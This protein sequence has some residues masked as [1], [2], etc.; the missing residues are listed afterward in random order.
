MSVPNLS[1]SVEPTE[2]GKAVYLPLAPPFDGGEGQ[3]KIV[4]C[5]TMTNNSG[6][7]LDV[8]KIVYSFPGTS[9]ADKSMTVLPLSIAA[10][11]TAQW[12]NG[13]GTNP[14]ESTFYD[15][16]YLDDA[17]PK[18]KVAVSC[19]GFSSP[20]TKT[21]DL[22]AFSSPNGSGGFLFPFSYADLREDEFMAASA[23]HWANGGGPGTQIF[24]HD[25]GCVGADNG[26]KETLDDKD[27]SKNSHWRIWGK[28]VRAV[29]DGVVLSFSDGMDTNTV[30]GEFPTPTPSP[31]GGNNIWVQHG[32]Y[33]V[34]YCHFQKNT[35][36]AKLKTGTPASPVKVK[37]GD[38]L[39]KAGNS[40]NTTNPHTHI[41]CQKTDSSGALRG[42]PW[43]NMFVSEMG[44]IDDPPGPDGPWARVSGKGVPLE[45]VAIWPLRRNPRWL[46]WQDLGGTIKSAPAV[47]SWEAHRL[48]VFARGMDDALWHK[49][50][51]GS[52]WH[53][54]QSLGGKFK[55][56]PA[57]VSWGA[58]RIDVFV[59][60][61]D[62]ALWHKWWDGSTWHDWQS[63]GGK[64]T[65]G[66]AVSSWEAHRLDV[67]AKGMDEKLW[68]KWWDGAKWHDWQ[69]LGGTF[70]GSPAAVS[71]GAH[72]IDVFVR[73]MDD[74]MGHLLYNGSDWVGWEDL[75]GGLTGAPAAASWEPHRLDVF[76]RRADE[77]LFHKWWNGSR[78]RGWDFVGGEFHD[79][80]AAV[81]WG[82]ERIDV[83]VRGMD[84]HLGHLWR[85]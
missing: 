23:D 7:K 30:L 80:P 26:W 3:V 6:S 29:A 77:E 78:W 46:G 71:W 61:M 76:A 52:T 21:V 45:W 49:W 85:T 13:H 84:D 34:Q 27:G 33:A 47:S 44:K 74:H 53:N 19:K 16:I 5:L 60:G 79:R 17:P 50:W 18:V 36:P 8:S 69:G 72:R 73:G 39:G 67:F 62:D 28:S 9:V 63:L 81:S 59:R 75:G 4:L 20:K 22:A 57:A 15:A 42:L 11:A 48:D 40:G 55:D 12:S 32:D 31:A 54:W 66:P 82:D 56:S 43:R 24:A 25:I 41:Q 2:S 35:I 83:F 68:H 64:I 70:K 51:D 58:H 38:V 1:I 37:A 10:G 14:D 65:S